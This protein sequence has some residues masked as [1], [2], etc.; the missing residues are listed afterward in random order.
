MLTLNPVDEIPSKPYQRKWVRALIL[1]DI[2][3]GQ[4]RDVIMGLYNLTLTEYK[5]L[6]RTTQ[7][8]SKNY[9]KPLVP[10]TKGEDFKLY[11][12]WTSGASEVELCE[13]YD[14]VLDIVIDALNRAAEEDEEHCRLC[15]GQPLNQTSIATKT[16]DPELD[17]LEKLARKK[18]PSLL[19]GLG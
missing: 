2:L 15:G 17:N 11:D 19:R 1:K 8:L 10:L 6:L 7:R 13:K 4:E 5:S 18:L 16:K 12:E 14:L 9:F 3:E